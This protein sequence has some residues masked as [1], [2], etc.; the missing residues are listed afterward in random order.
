MGTKEQTG[1]KD[2]WTG[3]YKDYYED[4]FFSLLTTSRSTLRVLGIR[5][6]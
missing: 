4:A 1:H 3:L 6:E 2:F 5:L